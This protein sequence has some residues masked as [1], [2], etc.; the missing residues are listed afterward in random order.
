MIRKSVIL[1]MV[2]L[3]SVSAEAAETVPW[4]AY[5]GDQTSAVSWSGFM[6][7]VGLRST[8]MSLA[9]ENDDSLQV[10]DERLENIAGRVEGV[11]AER[12]VVL[13]VGGLVSGRRQEHVDTFMRR[14]ERDGGKAWK[15]LVY[16]QTARIARLPGARQRVYWQVGNEINSRH[17]SLSLH[18]WAGDE[19]GEKRSS[20]GEQARPGPQRRRAFDGDRAARG[21]MRPGGKRQRRSGGTRNDDFIIGYY[22]EY[23]LAPT[24]EA[25]NRASK[26]VYGSPHKVNIVL[27]SLAGSRSTGARSWLD[28]LLDYR[29]KGTYAGSLAG[30]RVSELVD[31]IAIHYLV[32][33]PG[34]HWRTVLE[35]LRSRWVGRDRISGVW[36]TE[37]LGRRRAIRGLGAVTTT[38]VMFRYLDWALREGLGPKSARVNFWGGDIGGNATSGESALGLIYQFT[39]NVPLTPWARDAFPAR[40]PGI[41][42]Y[43]FSTPDRKRHMVALFSS[44]DGGAGTLGEVPVNVAGLREGMNATLQLFDSQGHSE[45]PVRIRKDNQRWLLTPAQPVDLSSDVTAVFFLAND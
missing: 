31:I 16:R 37:E 29:V 41:E 6:R 40:D 33:Y 19:L 10:L 17:Y 38:R 32:S 13:P 34:D 5:F 25:I 20:D 35:D 2:V 26:D 8:G 23:F 39:G 21:G 36:S 24:V 3:A 42:V 28:K 22:V 9:Q 15:E 44:G 30:R 45:L 11:I 14:I 18:T 27:G 4:T 1:A 7:G 12:D 43:G